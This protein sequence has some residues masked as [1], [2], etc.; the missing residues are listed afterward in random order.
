M[1]IGFLRMMP[2]MVLT[3]PANEVELKLALEFALGEDKPVAI[4]YPKDLVPEKRFARAACTRPY[5]LGESVVVKRRKDSSAAIV[6]YGSVLQE[7]LEAARLLAKGGIAVDVINAR[8][9]APVDKRIISLAAEGKFMVT[10]EDHG[11][12]CG[13][14]AAVLELASSVLEGPFEKPIKV[15]GAPRGFIRHDSRGRQLME[16]GV[17]AD[18]IVQAVKE[19]LNRAERPEPFGVST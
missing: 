18:K 14:G 16:S 11:L 13:F 3:A 4:R 6:S 15:L 19:L 5:R 2:N 1:D 10:V 9:A 8:F 17:N 12:A 7:A